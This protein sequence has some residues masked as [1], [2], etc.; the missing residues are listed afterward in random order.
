MNSKQDARAH[1]IIVGATI[2]AIA[3]TALRLA[4]LAR[5]AIM[6]DR[7]VAA[8]LLFQSSPAFTE[9]VAPGDTIADR[10]FGQPDFFHNSNNFVDAQSMSRL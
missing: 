10:E 9:P 4:P 7:Q 5:S 2:A 8:R 3:L 6:A 1:R